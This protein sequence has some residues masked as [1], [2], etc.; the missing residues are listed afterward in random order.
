MFATYLVIF[1]YIHYMLCAVPQTLIDPEMW[2]P[3]YTM[4]FFLHA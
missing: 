1:V 3:H 2:A 4:S